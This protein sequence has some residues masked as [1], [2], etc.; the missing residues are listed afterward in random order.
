MASGYGKRYANN[1]EQHG[2]KWVSKVSDHLQY[3]QQKKLFDA[4]CLWRAEQLDI[5]DIQICYDFM[6][7]EKDILNCPFIDVLLGHL[8]VVDKRDIY[9]K[10]YPSN[11]IF[12]QI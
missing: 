9:S 12:Y 4:Q 1:E 5:P 10:S 3:I 6:I 11:Q 7:W 2:I 8:E